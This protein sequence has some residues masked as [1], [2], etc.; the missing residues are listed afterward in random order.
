[1][2][3]AA[4]AVLNQALALTVEDQQWL[5]ERLREEADESGEE[6]AGIEGYAEWREELDRRLQSVA[7][8]T[9]ELIPFEEAM[10]Q[11][12]DEVAKRV[13]R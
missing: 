3:E 6:G 12:R 10:Q 11:I 2:S 1:M 13:A 9:A 7:D 4:Q 8:G 5:I